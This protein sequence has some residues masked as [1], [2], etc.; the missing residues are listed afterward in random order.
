MFCTCKNVLKNIIIIDFLINLT[1]RPPALVM[2]NN[3]SH[4]NGL[5]VRIEIEYGQLVEG[6]HTRTAYITH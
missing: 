5:I 6:V 2:G 3:E 4:W 1:P